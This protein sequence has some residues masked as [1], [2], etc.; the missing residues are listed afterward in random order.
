MAIKLLATDMDDTLL[1]HDLSISPGNK[2]ALEA[3]EDLGVHIVLASGRSLFSMSPYVKSLGIDTHEGYVISWNGALVT[4]AQTQKP[5]FEYFLEPSVINEAIDYCVKHD[6]SLQTQKDSRIFVINVNRYAE[7]DVAVS[8]MELVPSDREGFLSM[9][10]P[11]LILPGDPDALTPIENMLKP[12]FGDR[13]RLFRS[14]PYFLEIMPPEAD[15]GLA[16]AHLAEILGVKQEEVMA[17]GDAGNDKHMIEWAGIGV[18][19]ANA[20]EE[21][22]KVANWVTTKTNDEDGFAEALRRFVL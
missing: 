11:K 17:I 21:V 20:T 2:E 5:L 16:L 1:S 18:A 4:D 7:L 8:K 6:L 15:K 12:H 3:A 19:M 14:K 10:L 9:P 13:A 22:R